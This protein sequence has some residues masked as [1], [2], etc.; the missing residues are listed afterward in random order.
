MGEVVNLRRVRKA[1]ARAAAAQNA[2]ENRVK[3]GRTRAAQGMDSA[4]AE[5]RAL[6]HEG[7]R[8]DGGD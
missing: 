1:K 3:H 8:L 5:R 2:A 4:S 6:L 7:H